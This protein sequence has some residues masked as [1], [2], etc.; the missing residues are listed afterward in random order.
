MKRKA[1]D[2]HIQKQEIVKAETHKYTNA[3][4]AEY[5]NRRDNGNL[6][7]PQNKKMKLEKNVENAITPDDTIASSPRQH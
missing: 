1:E 3:V 6:S 7:P 5:R 2:E 4:N